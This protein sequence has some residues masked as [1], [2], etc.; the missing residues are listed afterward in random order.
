MANLEYE[1]IIYRSQKPAMTVTRRILEKIKR[2][3]FDF[4]EGNLFN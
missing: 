4:L 3:G 2:A 1:Y